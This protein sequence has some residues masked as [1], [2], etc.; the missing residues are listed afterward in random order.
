L[1]YFDIAFAALVLGALLV[2]ARSPRAGAPV[3]ALLAVAGLWRPEAWVL[4]GAYALY[5]WPALEDRRA[6]VRALA[7]AA[8]APALWLPPAPAP[9]R[10]PAL[11][12]ARPPGGGGPAA[13]PARP[14]RRAPRAAAG[15]GPGR[16]P[17]RR[18]RRG[19]GPRPRARLHAPARAAA[20]RRLRGQ[21]RRDRRR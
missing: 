9:P 17:G 12:A 3:L 13:P 7:L 11:P 4:S 19:R 21:R 15:A 5:L 16:A 14:G 18:G 8:S 10:R 1:A 6:R 2:E 20:R